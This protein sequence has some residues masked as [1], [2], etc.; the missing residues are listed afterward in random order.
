MLLVWYILLVDGREF[1]DTAQSWTLL[2]FMQTAEK[3]E[4]LFPV[5][6]V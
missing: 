1:M 6:T 3:E 4:A 5:G 2:S